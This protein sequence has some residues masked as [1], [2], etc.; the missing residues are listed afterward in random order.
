M[1]VY[2]QHRQSALGSTQKPGLDKTVNLCYN[3]KL[4]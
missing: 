1:V 2:W 4:C 3:T